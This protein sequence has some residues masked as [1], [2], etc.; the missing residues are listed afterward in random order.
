[1]PVKIY[2]GPPGSYKTSSA[3]MDEAAR[4][5]REGRLLITNVRGLS[6]ERL[7]QNVPTYS[8]RDRLFGKKKDQRESFDMI[9]LRM[10]NPEELE[11]LRR[12]WHWAP[13]G[14]FFVLDEVQALYPTDWTA[15]QYHE[16]DIPEGQERVINGNKF[17]S[18]LSLAFDM[19]RHGNWDFCFTTPNIKKVFPAIR[20]AAETAYK[21][22]NMAM[23]GLRGRFMQFM[24]TAEDNG[25]PSETYGSRWRKIPGWVF[26]CYEST[27]TGA[28]SDS[29][30]GWSIL[31]NPKVLLLGGIL[32][33]C[34]AGLL[35]LGPPSLFRDKPAPVAP[36][37][38]SPDPADGV[39]PVP[40][41][42]GQP[43][44]FVV[45]GN[46]PSELWRIVGVVN[47]G[48]WLRIYVANKRRVRPL[49]GDNCRLDALGWFCRVEDGMA[50][51]WTGPEPE[52]D[53]AQRGLQVASDVLG[54]APKEP[55]P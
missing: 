4:C 3:V 32:L 14:A 8:L 33:A 17:A 18:Y 43:R 54:I 27:A 42:P 23:L 35:A 6:K 2:W 7:L 41:G 51:F 15:R 11:K 36:A 31:G 34:T 12:W 1:M 45:D 9:H 24:H 5:V 16:L 25:N 21:H 38:Q 22:K 49:P 20:G 28:V 30:A 10:D 13:V 48:K 37:T 52:V 40:Q 29:K 47:A 39:R 19:H 53:E 44:Q 26:R 50:T 46:Q 55:A